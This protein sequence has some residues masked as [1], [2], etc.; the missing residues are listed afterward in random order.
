MR[1]TIPPSW[2]EEAPLQCAGA[3]LSAVS[4]GN[5]PSVTTRRGTTTDPAPTVCYKPLKLRTLTGGVSKTSEG[6]A[7]SLSPGALEMHRC[8]KT[9]VKSMFPM[10]AME[11]VAHP[12]TDGM[13]DKKS[14][15]LGKGSETKCAFS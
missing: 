7:L 15:V 6:G 5:G 8:Q 3:L 10:P 12:I 4:A 11:V 2:R 13:V 14:C 9:T 1:F